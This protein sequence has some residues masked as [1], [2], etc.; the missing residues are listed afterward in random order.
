MLESALIWGAEAE[1]S[2]SAASYRF[3]PAQPKQWDAMGLEPQRPGQLELARKAGRKPG[4][5]TAQ[6]KAAF[7]SRTPSDK[8]PGEMEGRRLSGPEC[9]HLYPTRLL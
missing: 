9:T 5:A 2:P 6:N 1:V 3:I 4:L 8:R 7:F